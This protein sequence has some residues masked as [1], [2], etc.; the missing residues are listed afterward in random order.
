MLKEGAIS[1][2]DRNLLVDVDS[3]GTSSRGCFLFGYVKFAV[4][5]AF[6]DVIGYPEKA[7]RLLK[8]SGTIAYEA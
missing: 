3:P 4:H 2:P 1:H 8:K 7:S 5:S 6:S